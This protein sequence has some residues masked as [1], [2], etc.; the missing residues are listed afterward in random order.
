MY[1]YILFS[2]RRES[3]AEIEASR[4]NCLMQRNKYL[5]MKRFRESED[6]RLKD[7]IKG[8]EEKLEIEA[9]LER[10]KDQKGVLKVA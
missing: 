3:D 5:K 6:E 2:A 4:K 8:P 10:I 1:F 7:Q 9:D